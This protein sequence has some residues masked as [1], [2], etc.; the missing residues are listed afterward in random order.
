MEKHQAEKGSIEN[1]DPKTGL[2]EKEEPGKKMDLYEGADPSPSTVGQ[3]LVI[4]RREAGMTQKEAA[5]KLGIS[6]KTISRWETDRGLPDVDLLADV[7]GLYGVTVDELLAGKRSE[8]CRM[9]A[10]RTDAHWEAEAQSERAEDLPAANAEKPTA[11]QKNR[12]RHILGRYRKYL[13]GI[14][15]LLVAALLPFLLAKEYQTY[16]Q[17]EKNAQEYYQK[18]YLRLP[19]ANELEEVKALFQATWDDFTTQQ[20]AKRTW[21]IHHVQT[22]L[23]YMP[24]SIVITLA[25]WQ[26]GVLLIRLREQKKNGTKVRW[27]EI[28]YSA[29]LLAGAVILLATAYIAGPRYADEV[30]QLGE[31]ETYEDQ[32]S[33]DAYVNAYLDTYES[34]RKYY[35]SL[36][37]DM[38]ELSY[39]ITRIDQPYMDSI[40]PETATYEPYR[41]VTRFDYQTLTVYKAGHTADWID[42]MG[43]WNQVIFAAGLAELFLIGICFAAQQKKHSK[44]ALS[45]DQ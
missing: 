7:A 10:G 28:R 20:V 37:K 2:Y 39:G 24:M 30:Y 14:L 33:F 9:E 23:Q 32:E 43:R 18:R 11:S 3:F 36:G 44:K 42:A 29:A 8:M 25:L 13:V 27:Q 17:I 4:L 34:L 40:M 35:S 31:S 1:H 6:D 12:C 5:A 21:E 19:E 45:T 16:E 15:L 22:Y 41:T 38:P 26:L